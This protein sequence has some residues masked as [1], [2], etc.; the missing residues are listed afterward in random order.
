MS[1]L[2]ASGARVPPMTRVRTIVIITI[3]FAVRRA[4]LGRRVGIAAASA[5]L[6]S[7]PTAAIRKVISSRWRKS[8]LRA[9]VVARIGIAAIST[10]RTR[11]VETM[12][13]FRSWRSAKTPARGAITTAGTV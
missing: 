13:S 5:G 10:P 4:S 9:G 7:W 8:W 6:K 3:E 12:I 2:E 11:L 1:T